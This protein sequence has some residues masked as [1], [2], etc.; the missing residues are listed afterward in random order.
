MSKWNEL[1]DM[2]VKTVI[3][4][5]TH[6]GLKYRGLTSGLP[7]GI[8]CKGDLKFFRYSARGKDCIVYIDDPKTPTEF[9]VRPLQ[10]IPVSSPDSYSR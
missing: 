7:V 9:I 6:K 4:Y 10:P 8:S 3:H 5:L 2:D 1:S